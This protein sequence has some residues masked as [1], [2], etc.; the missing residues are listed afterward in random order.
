MEQKK[1]VGEEV[2]QWAEKYWLIDKVCKGEI[3]RGEGEA[4]SWETFRGAFINAING[5]IE[6]RLNPTEQ[7]TQEN[8]LN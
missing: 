1:S 8:S 4:F 7:P 6:E 3:G 5:N 2:M